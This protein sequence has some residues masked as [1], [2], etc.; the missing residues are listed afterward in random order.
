MAVYEKTSEHALGM[1][2]LTG[3]RE[4]LNWGHNTQTTRTMTPFYEYLIRERVSSRTFESFDE[5]LLQRIQDL[6]GCTRGWFW[7]KPP[8][9]KARKFR[10]MK[11]TPLPGGTERYPLLVTVST[12]K[13]WFPVR[14][15]ALET[16][17]RRV[18][19]EVVPDEP[20]AAAD[21]DAFDLWELNPDLRTQ[22]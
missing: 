7:I 4:L 8:E 15:P 22:C 5:F 18:T 14:L 3:C 13:P 17:V 21:E 1:L 9:K 19:P 20:P 2:A 10:A 11:I 12:A 6:W 16:P